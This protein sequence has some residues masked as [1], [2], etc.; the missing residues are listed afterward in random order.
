MSDMYMIR[1]SD[2]KN[3]QV[4]IVPDS[5]ESH[6]WTHFVGSTIEDAF[7]R[8]INKLE[9]PE[10]DYQAESTYLNPKGTLWLASES[11]VYGEDHIRRFLRIQVEEES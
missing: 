3:P 7:N 11:S 8:A 6:P 1:I 10:K 4:S 5:N 2:G 9:H